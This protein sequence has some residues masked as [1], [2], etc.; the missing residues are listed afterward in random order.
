MLMKF[1]LGEEEPHSMAPF[2]RRNA[3]QS[4]KGTLVF[5]FWALC[6]PDSVPYLSLDAIRDCRTP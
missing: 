6:H 5:L 1:H 3:I 4:T 2:S